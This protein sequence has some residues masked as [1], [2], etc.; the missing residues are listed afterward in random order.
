MKFGLAATF[1]EFIMDVFDGCSED[2]ACFVFEGAVEYEVAVI[3]IC[4]YSR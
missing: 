1:G 2:R 3:V 4:Y